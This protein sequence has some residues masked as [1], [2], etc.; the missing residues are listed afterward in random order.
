MEILREEKSTDEE[1]TSAHENDWVQKQNPS[2]QFVDDERWKVR[3]RYGHDADN[4]RRG[5]WSDCAAGRLYT[6]KPIFR[7]EQWK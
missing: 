5:V 6:I 1:R 3:G 7:N 4:D 2:S